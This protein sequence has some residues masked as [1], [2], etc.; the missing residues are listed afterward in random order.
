MIVFTPL[1]YSLGIAQFFHTDLSLV[2][3]DAA[4]GD[5]YSSVQKRINIL[6][7]DLNF[8]LFPQDELLK[9]DVTLTGVFEEES[10]S[11]VLNFYDNMDIEKVYLNGK[12]TDFNLEDKKFYVKGNYEFPDTFKLRMIYSGSPRR[13]GF[14]SFAFDEYNDTSFIYTISEPVYASTWFPCNDLPA[15]KAIAD[16]RITNDSGMVSLSNGNLVGVVTSGN[17]KTYHWRTEYPVSTYLLAV[18][19]ADYVNFKDL[20]IT[21]KGDSIKFDYY[22][23]PEKLAAAKIDFSVHPEIM[24]FFRHKFGEYPFIKEKYGVAE[25]LWPYGAIEN[26]TIMGMGSRFIGGRKLFTDIYIHE[27]AHQWWGN[28]VG[29]ATWMDVWLNEGFCSYSEALYFE[30]KSGKSA[31]K[32]T[33]RSKHLDFTNS[34][35]YNPEK[36]IFTRT[37]YDKGAWILHMLRKEVGDSIFFEIL[38]NYY[39]AYKYKNAS[40]NDFKVVVEKISGTNFTKFFDQWIYSGKGE[41]E[42]EYEFLPELVSDNQYLNKIKL[43]QVQEFY[44]VYSFPL[45][46]LVQFEENEPDEMFSFK[47]TEK[48]TMLILNTNQKIKNLIMDPESELLATIIKKED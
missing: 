32:S 34:T 47:I 24:N 5:Y 12:E 14:G 9:G 20:L 40:T 25:I 45:D 26:Q 4:F 6:H 37:I 21:E 1:R 36:P 43:T 31:L 28:S 46:I 10:D 44:D 48:E 3:G 29:P 15:D 23:L 13:L 11:L 22:V 27:L 8:D 7:Y 2:S 18:Y 38:R 30:Y 39:S 42:C 41:I 19:S 17:R 16:I 35:V 33:M